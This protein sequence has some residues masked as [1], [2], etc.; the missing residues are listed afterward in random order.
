MM[1]WLTDYNITQRQ[2]SWYLFHHLQGSMSAFYVNY[3][4]IRLTL[5]AISFFLPGVMAP[6]RAILGAI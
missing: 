1:R 5:V 3:A 4:S 2:F 6:L